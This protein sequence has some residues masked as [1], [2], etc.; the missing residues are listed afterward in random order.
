MS[1]E[2]EFSLED[3]MR[4]SYR[5]I[6]EDAPEEEIAEEEPVSERERDERGS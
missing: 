3:S 1:D 6:T 5:E 2:D 4:E